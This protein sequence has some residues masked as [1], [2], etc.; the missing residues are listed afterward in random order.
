MSKQQRKRVIISAILAAVVLLLL[1]LDWREIVRDD[2]RQI[3]QRKRLVWLTDDA[4]WGF[5]AQ[6][7]DSMGFHYELIKAYADSMGLELE[8]QIVNGRNEQLRA[9]RKHKAHVLATD[10]LLTADIQQQFAPCP[11]P[12]HARI[13]LVSSKTSQHID[14]LRQLD[15]KRVL[16]PSDEAYHMR[17][18]HLMEELEIEIEMVSGKHTTETDIVQNV[19]HGEEEYGLCLDIHAHPWVATYPDLDFS[20]SI[21]FEQPC[22]WVVNQHNQELQQ[23]LQHFLERFVSTPTYRQLYRK[24]FSRRK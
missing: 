9:L 18:E 15:G 19:Q 1:C 22:G 24:Y 21:G 12:Y 3:T 10:V 23:S 20:R 14:D 4:H 11:L 17:L 6:C 7:K 5:D 8:V 13:Q 16:V 2:Y